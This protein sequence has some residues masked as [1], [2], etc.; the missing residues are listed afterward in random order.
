MQHSQLNFG[1]RLDPQ[2]VE[3]LSIWS[4]LEIDV[5]YSLCCSG[6]VCIRDCKWKQGQRK[7]TA[8]PIQIL[9]GSEVDLL[10][11]TV[12]YIFSMEGLDD[13]KKSKWTSNLRQNL[14]KSV[15]TH[16][17]EGCCKINKGYEN[18]LTLLSALLLKLMY[19]ENIDRGLVGTEAT[20]WF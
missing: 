19:R 3:E 10:K 15:P 18:W 5:W 20:M 13:A 4:T 2:E 12:P 9:K 16:E 11:T 14:K 8:L 7:D 1:L 17:V 6:K